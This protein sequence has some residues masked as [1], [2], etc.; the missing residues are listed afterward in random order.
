[1]NKHYSSSLE[2]F[3]LDME[4]RLNELEWRPKLDGTNTKMNNERS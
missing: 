1:M 4:R 3:V 2:H